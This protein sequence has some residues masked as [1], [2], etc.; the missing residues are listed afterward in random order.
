MAIPPPAHTKADDV[1]LE[2]LRG[3]GTAGRFA[4]ASALPSAAIELSRSE[5]RAR[6]PDLDDVGV[7]LRWAEIHHGAELAA[8]LRRH[9]GR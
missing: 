2:L 8:K 7:R 1:Q 9:L 4:L 5:I 3:L 6:E